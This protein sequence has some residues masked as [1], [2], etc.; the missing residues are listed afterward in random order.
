[1]SEILYSLTNPQKSI[2]LTGEFYKGTS[3]ENITGSVIVS[4]KVNFDILKKAINLFV[5]KNDSFRLKFV[6]KGDVVK[7]YVDS[8]TEFDIETVLVSSDKDVECLERQICDTR[9]KTLGNFLFSFKLFKFEDGHG[10][11]IINAHHLIS[12]AWTAGLVVNEIMG[13]YEVLQNGENISEELN[14]SYIEYI[15]SENKYLNSEKFE[16]DKTFW[17]EMYSIVPEIATIPS[18]A[19]DTVN[20]C[21]SK[22]K[23]FTIPK[24]T[25]SLINE[26]CKNNKASVFNFFRGIFSLYLS[27]VCG[28]VEFLIVTQILNISNFKE[29]KTTGMFISTIP[30]KVSIDNTKS[31]GEFI[32]D[33]S[34]DFS[35]I[36]RHQ[37]YPYQYLLKD[38]REKDNNIPNLY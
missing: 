35:K 29:K 21:K 2:W 1:M 27:R 7:Q 34:S 20:S 33:M 8:Y 36:Y 15:E 14:P 16:K 9:F 22:R 24:E 19:S 32:A 26:F 5:K 10:G 17:N 23:Q 12:D 6:L 4:Q 3:I 18:F 31:F 30:F 25:I 28:L 11:F 13:Y 38:L 37:K